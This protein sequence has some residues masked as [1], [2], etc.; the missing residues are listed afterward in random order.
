MPLQ[1]LTQKYC[2]QNKKSPLQRLQGTFNRLTR[3]YFL[4]YNSLKNTSSYP[5]SA[6]QLLFNKIE[7]ETPNVFVCT[8][9]FKYLIINAY[10]N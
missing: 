5:P 2:F 8:I 4:K 3:Y 10:I 1:S 9:L 7:T 6:L